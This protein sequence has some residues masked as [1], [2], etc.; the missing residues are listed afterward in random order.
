MPTK[1]TALAN[2]SEKSMPSEILPLQTANNIA[3]FF[4]LAYF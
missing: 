3:P 1:N 4:V 2:S